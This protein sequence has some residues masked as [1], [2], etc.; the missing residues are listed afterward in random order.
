LPSNIAAICFFW[1]GDSV[2]ECAAAKAASANAGEPE[3]EAAEAALVPATS[4]KPTAA[5]SFLDGISPPRVGTGF[6]TL[7][8]APVCQHPYENGDHKMR[9]AQA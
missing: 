4:S 9:H 7:M 2:G 5:S 1:A 6:S 3:I 8:M